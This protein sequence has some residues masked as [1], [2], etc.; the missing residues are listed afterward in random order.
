MVELDQF[1]VVV[2]G[3]LLLIGLIGDL[4]TTLEIKK[5]PGRL[6]ER[7][8]FQ[9]ELMRKGL[10]EVGHLVVLIVGEVS[11]LAWRDNVY[12]LLSLALLGGL[13]I[14]T[15]IHNIQVIQSVQG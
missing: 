10:F 9:R 3:L 2:V 11:L 13:L 12:V 5:Y 7:N 4:M 14:F 6:Y 15:T 1:F 8:P